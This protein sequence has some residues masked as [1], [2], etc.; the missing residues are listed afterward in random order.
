MGS[1][2]QWGQTMTA[3]DI[4]T[5][6]GSAGGDAGFA[7]DGSSAAASL[8]QGPT[9]LAFDS[10]ENLYISD[11]YN[12]EIREVAAT[13]HS[14]W[15][16]SMTANDI[17]DVAGN[18]V[19]TG[20]GD[21]GHDGNG[22]AATSAELLVPSGLAFDAAGDLFIA[23]SWNNR[24]QEVPA[25]LHAQWGQSMTAGDIYTVAGSADGD[26]GE[27]GLGV[28][29]TSAL[30]SGVPSI[31]LDSAGDLYI[32]DTGN[33]EIDEVAAST[34]DQ[35]ARTSPLTTSMAL[36]EAEPTVTAPWPSMSAST[37]HRESP[38][39]PAAI[40]SSPIR[41]T[42]EFE[43]SLPRQALIKRWR[44]QRVGRSGLTT[45]RGHDDRRVHPHIGQYGHRSDVVLRVAAP[46]VASLAIYRGVDTSNPIDVSS[47]AATTSG[48][49][50]TAPSVT[51]THDG[52]ELVSID[53]G[54]GQA[55][56]PTW[57]E[58]DGFT[59][60]S[61]TTTSGVSESI[62]DGIGP[63]SAGSTGSISASTSSSGALAAVDLAVAP[64]DVTTTTTAYTAD[65]QP[66]LVTDADGNASLTCYDGDGNVT[67]TVPPVG[68][69]ANALTPASCPTDYPSGQRQLASDATFYSYNA[70][71]E[72]TF[73][74]YPSA[75]GSSPW[76]ETDN[77]YD[78]AGRLTGSTSSAN[79][80]ASD[81]PGN[82]TAYNYDA[83]GEV[84]TV[85]V[86]G[87][88]SSASLT[89]YCYDPD[90]DKTAM[91][92][93]DGYSSISGGCESSYPYQTT[94]P[95]QTGYFYD[96]IGE[97]ASQ[98]APATT[99][100][101]SGQTTTY[102][103]DAD[104][105]QL[106]SVSPGGVTTTNTYTPLDQTA[107]TSY[108][109]TSAP[110]V[111]YTYDADGNRTQMTDGTGT[112][113]YTYDPFGEMTSSENGDGK[114]VHYAYDSLGN[115]TGITYPFGAPGPHGHHPTRLPTDMTGRPR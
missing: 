22:G 72:V 60:V 85:V 93:P 87:G 40:C 114:T 53:G 8:M 23:D 71:N 4:Y 65:D 18:G 95:Y 20:D 44:R 14:Q 9:G 73:K 82:V 109:S 30:F 17:Y 106:T 1:G 55:G 61:D 59:K 78:A 112:S 46:K 86:E 83:A 110:A 29:A 32:T 26:S 101:P 81:D 51:T 104:G 7:G 92:A 21:Y 64:T 47:T 15:G 36:P 103:Y 77:V 49:A 58:P 115:V 107:T 13:T 105:N 67:Q 3:G 89:Q 80:P 74:G 28:A 34:G 79:S 33:D 2:T 45:L 19:N 63:A 57:T 70:L 35:R 113:T 68:V 69:A 56:T 102:T 98:T 66:T 16:Q 5:I 37:T 91:V 39:I 25:N 50:V 38:S 62:A 96:S 97:L 75:G 41:P 111:S 10:E 24:V 108:S 31:S 27:S 52:D 12:C 90:G 88:T 99:A 11:S 94:S 48:T 76:A 100:A 43:S 54:S 84:E 42:T 6:A